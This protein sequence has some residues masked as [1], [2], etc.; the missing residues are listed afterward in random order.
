[1]VSAL[2]GMFC[3]RLRQLSTI[4]DHVSVVCGHRVAI[5]MKNWPKMGTWYGDVMIWVGKV[6]A[7]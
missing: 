6:V 7:D 3:G 1:M 2:G 4:H 5:N